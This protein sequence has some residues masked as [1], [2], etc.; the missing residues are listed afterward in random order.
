MRCLHSQPPQQQQ[1]L[2][3]TP[4]SSTAAAQAALQETLA[5][6]QQQFWHLSTEIGQTATLPFVPLLRISGLTCDTG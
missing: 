2:C 3:P 4:C 5:L 6:G 1:L